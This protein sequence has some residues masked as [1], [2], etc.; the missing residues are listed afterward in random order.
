MNNAGKEVRLSLIN[1]MHAIVKL[2]ISLLIAIMVSAA[3]NIQGIST[4]SRVI[5]GWDVFCITTLL[6]YWTSFFSTP[7]GHIRK[8]AANDDPSRIIVFIIVLICTFASMTVVVQLLTL[9]KSE[10]NNI[11][12]SIALAG[13]IL[14]WL[15]LHTI[16][17][18]RYAH[19]YYSGKKDNSI[20]QKPALDFP[21]DEHPD[22]L[23]F[24]YFSFVLGMTFQVSDVEIASKKIRQMALLH[25]LISFAYNTV[26]VALTINI[27]AGLK[28]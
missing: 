8:E 16:F 1:R 22:F 12:L 9:K 3:F 14:T 19:M 24:A 28:N 21:D 18:A 4:L 27:I 10:T 5:F 13:M 15:L 26:V 11:Q 2:G 6:V 23:D 17:T 20:E 7:Q 25:G